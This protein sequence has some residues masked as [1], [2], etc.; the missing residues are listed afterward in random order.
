MRMHPYIQALGASQVVGE[1][2][3]RFLSQLDRHPKGSLDADLIRR[4]HAR[5]EDIVF[6]GMANPKRH[7]F[8]AKESPLVKKTSC[9]I[10]NRLGHLVMSTV[11]GHWF[12]PTPLCETCQQ[13]S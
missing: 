5:D 11:D 2:V 8:T 4:E 13:G 1:R 9:L 3:V 6:C 10:E 7:P 12:T